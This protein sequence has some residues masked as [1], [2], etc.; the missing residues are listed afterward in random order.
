[1]AKKANS[2]ELKI[3]VKYEN[4]TEKREEKSLQHIMQK[5]FDS[6]ITKVI[7]NINKDK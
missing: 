4:S 5:L 6:Y 7:Q 2:K 1:M 3:I